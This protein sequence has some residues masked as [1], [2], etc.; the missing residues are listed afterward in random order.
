MI[1]LLARSRS[2][3]SPYNVAD[4]SHG[5]RICHQEHADKDR[6]VAHVGPDACVA[7]VEELC[8]RA[9]GGS[10]RGSRHKGCRRLQGTPPLRSSRSTSSVRSCG[11]YKYITVGQPAAR[12]PSQWTCRGRRTRKA[13][14]T[15]STVLIQRLPAGTGGASTEMGGVTLTARERRT[16]TCTLLT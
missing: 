11:M 14:P 10:V 8:G 12:P 6:E 2:S 9:G 13:Y 16:S 7:H 3:L 15:G 4:E 1:T 5:E